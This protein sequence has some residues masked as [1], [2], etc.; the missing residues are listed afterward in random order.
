MRNVL[1]GDSL[2]QGIPGSS[3][4][5]MLRDVLRGLALPKK[6]IPSLYFYDQ[7]G[8]ELFDAITELPERQ[9]HCLMMYYDR[10]M[11]LAEIGAVYSVSVS[12]ISQTAAMGM[13][14]A[15]WKAGSGSPGAYHR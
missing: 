10:E 14:A 8:S 3:Y 9:R 1:V 6:N 4:A 2:M 11:S 12:R 13:M 15:W 5:V 7:R